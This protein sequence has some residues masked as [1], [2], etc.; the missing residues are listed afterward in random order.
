MTEISITT[1]MCVAPDAV[2][3]AQRLQFAVN[4]LKAKAKDREIRRRVQST[5]HCSWATA[6]RTV[7]MARDIA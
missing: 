2:E 5:Y 3:R 7:D 1:L 6:W 4:L